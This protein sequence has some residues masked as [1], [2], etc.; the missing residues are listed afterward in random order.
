MKYTA[1]GC[2]AKETADLIFRDVETVKMYRKKLFLKLD[3]K[4]MAEL[5][6]KGYEM[7][8]I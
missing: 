6:K 2:T 4:N 8:V 7:K 5:I 3:A 1:E